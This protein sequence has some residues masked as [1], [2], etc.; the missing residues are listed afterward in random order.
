[1]SQALISGLLGISA[2]PAVSATVWIAPLLQQKSWSLRLSS[3][4]SSVWRGEL[5]PKLFTD[6]LSLDWNPLIETAVMAHDLSWL[7]KITID[8]VGV[9]A[10]IQALRFEVSA[11]DCAADVERR[12][13]SDYFDPSEEEQLAHG[14]KWMASWYRD[15][16]G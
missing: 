9:I 13:R 12:I 14:C 6:L 8:S 16:V 2:N 4:Y 1:M 7:L 11:L 3:P 15:C 10:F 5:S